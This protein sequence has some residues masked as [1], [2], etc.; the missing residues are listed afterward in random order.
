MATTKNIPA[1]IND[2]TTNMRFITKNNTTGSNI[3]ARGRNGINSIYGNAFRH[4]ICVILSIIRHI[5]RPIFE[6]TAI[7]LDRTIFI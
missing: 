4:G 1:I 3:K 7:D 6:N 5:S 2:S